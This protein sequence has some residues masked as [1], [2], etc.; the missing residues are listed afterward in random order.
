MFSRHDLVWLTPAGWDA[1]LALAPHAALHQWRDHDWPA[2]VRRQEPGLGNN[3]VCLGMPLPASYGVRQRV[4]LVSH[5][6]HVARRQ[7][8]LPLNDVIGAAPPAWLAGLVALQ[9]ATSSFDLRVYGSLAMACV[10][11]EAH[12]RPES[13]ID[14]LLRP[15]TAGE[16]GAG[17]ALLAE[18]AA[19][20][21]LDGEIVFPSGEAVAWKEWLAADHSRARVLAKSRDAVR[22]VEPA[23]LLA[24]LEP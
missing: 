5:V 4:A 23:H 8:P 18:H 3:M 15:A 10:T 24:T 21:P 6:D 2:V 19:L 17:I 9:R 20:L 12:L 11:G 1:A 13:D 16:L 7:A 14:L 22:L